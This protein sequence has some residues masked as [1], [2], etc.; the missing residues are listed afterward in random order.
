MAVSEYGCRMLLFGAA[1][2][3]NRKKTPVGAQLAP[4]MSIRRS[5]SADITTAGKQN[6]GLGLRLLYWL[7]VNDSPMKNKN[8]VLENTGFSSI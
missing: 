7:S 5:I 8:P 2:A 4:L 6:D 3:P 1:A